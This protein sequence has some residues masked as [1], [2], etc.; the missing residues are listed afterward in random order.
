MAEL[1]ASWVAVD[2]ARYQSAEECARDW[3]ARGFGG[4][5]ASCPSSQWMQTTLPC[6]FGVD[7]QTRQSEFS[8][9]GESRSDNGTMPQR[10]GTV[11]GLRLSLLTSYR[12]QLLT[13]QPGTLQQAIVI[14]DVN[15]YLAALTQPAEKYV[16]R[17]GSL[18]SAQLYV[19]KSADSGETLFRAPYVTESI[20]SARAS[21]ESS[22]SS[23][24][25][26]ESSVTFNDEDPGV[27]AVAALKRALARVDIAPALV[28]ALSLPDDDPVRRLIVNVATTI[29]DDADMVTARLY[30]TGGGAHSFVGEVQTIGGL[31][32]LTH[33]A[34]ARSSRRHRT[35][36]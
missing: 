13:T 1:G 27:A 24:A 35:T 12:S 18:P 17:I 4:D 26:P 31:R 16:Q 11:V 3:L 7:G 36:R 6:N 20:A 15:H 10:M 28:L 9:F 25:S 2:G 14:H 32:T 8:L 29:Q 21:P 5:Y 19:A 30:S 33:G 34:G 23:R 22:A